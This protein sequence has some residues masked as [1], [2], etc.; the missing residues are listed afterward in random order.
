MD[1]QPATD[2]RAQGWP[3]AT[4]LLAHFTAV[5]LLAAAVVI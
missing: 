2:G 5:L 1:R 3:V 4:L